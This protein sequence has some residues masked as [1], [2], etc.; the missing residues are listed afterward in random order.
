[1]DDTGTI[2]VIYVFFFFLHFIW[3]FS[4]FPIFDQRSIGNL[5]SKIEEDD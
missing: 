5:G 3:E 1:M 4:M 2:G